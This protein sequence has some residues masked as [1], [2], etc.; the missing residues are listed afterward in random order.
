MS[1]LGLNEPLSDYYKMLYPDKSR[2]TD[3]AKRIRSAYRVAVKA[4]REEEEI[5][6]FFKEFKLQSNGQTPATYAVFKKGRQD[7]FQM[8]KIEC[9]YE[10]ELEFDPNK[11]NRLYCYKIL[12]ETGKN[13]DY[14]IDPSRDDKHSKEGI[15]V[16]TIDYEEELKK[17][18]IPSGY[19]LTNDLLQQLYNQSKK[20]ES[21]DEYVKKATSI[22]TLPPEVIKFYQR[23]YSKELLNQQLNSLRKG[24]LT[25]ATVKDFY[26][27]TAPYN[28]EA[29]VSEFM[30]SLKYKESKDLE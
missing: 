21:F 28:V 16:Y 1:S 25:F 15:Y 11:E 30:K 7:P 20:K 27:V 6:K 18:E 17:D 3:L 4:E 26:L 22:S 19:R 13:R 10:Y 12:T 5:E 14:S 8:L 9:D 24:T 2:A 29:T 23:L